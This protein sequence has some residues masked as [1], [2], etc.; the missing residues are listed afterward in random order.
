MV[1]SFRKSDSTDLVSGCEEAGVVLEGLF[2]QFTEAIK[3]SQQLLHVL[4]RVLDKHT[5][6]DTQTW[7]YCTCTKSSPPILT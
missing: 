3:Q 1:Q 7:N 5:Q 6:E 4:F 2:Y